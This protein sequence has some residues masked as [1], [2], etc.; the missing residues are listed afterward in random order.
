MLVCLCHKSVASI[1][2]ILSLLT[3]AECKRHKIKCEVKPGETSCT[4]CLKSGAK[5]VANDFSQR[6]VDDD[7]KWV[8][9][10]VIP[11]I[12]GLSAKKLD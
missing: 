7:V 6:F 8:T 10:S 11:F 9:A 4:K 2:S 12:F 3:G 1:S 5:C